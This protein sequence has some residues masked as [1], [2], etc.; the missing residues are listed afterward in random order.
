MIFSRLHKVTIFHIHGEQFMK[1]KYIVNLL[2]VKYMFTMLQTQNS[3]F[4]HID[5]VLQTSCKGKL[6]LNSLTLS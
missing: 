1:S 6:F 2:I 3:F 4:I 5:H